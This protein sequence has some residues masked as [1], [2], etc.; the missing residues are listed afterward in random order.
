MLKLDVLYAIH[1]V[2]Y[3]KRK[4][5]TLVSVPAFVKYVGVEHILSFGL[6]LALL[7]QLFVELAQLA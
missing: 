2:I 3:L 1:S 5:C 7:R 6:Q 4:Q